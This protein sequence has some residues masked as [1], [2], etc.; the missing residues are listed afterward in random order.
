MA[1]TPASDD[2][3]SGG[4]CISI[5]SPYTLSN[6]SVLA[7]LRISNRGWP[8]PIRRSIFSLAG[9]A[10]VPFRD[11]SLTASGAGGSGLTG[12]GRLG[13]DGI[14]GSTGS[15]AGRGRTTVPGAGGA[16]FVGAVG[17]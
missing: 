5:F 15:G 2:L 13:R 11:G 10:V 9:W 16:G 17:V 8:S 7:E 14:G 12:S 4:A 6:S 3:P 1:V